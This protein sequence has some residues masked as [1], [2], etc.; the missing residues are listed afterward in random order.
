MAAERSRLRDEE[1][2]GGTAMLELFG[3][4]V[5]RTYTLTGMKRRLR[6]R[7]LLKEHAFH[8]VGLERAIRILP[9]RLR[10][11]WPQGATERLERA[12]AGWLG[13]Y[14]LLIVE[15]CDPDVRGAAGRA[16]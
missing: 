10:A 8:R 14:M 6:G 15:K 5:I 3:C 4:P 16:S 12:L 2:I 11:R 13:F 1:T 9:A 7:F